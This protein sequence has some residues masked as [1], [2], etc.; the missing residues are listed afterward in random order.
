MLSSLCLPSLDVNQGFG[1]N[2]YIDFQIP[3]LWLSSF[4]NFPLDFVSL[5]LS[6]SPSDQKILSE[7][8]LPTMAP[9]G[10][11]IF[12]NPLVFPQFQRILSYVEGLVF[13]L[14]HHVE[15][16]ILDSLRSSYPG[17]QEMWH[18]YPLSRSFVF[19]LVLQMIIHENNCVVCGERYFH[20][21]F[22]IITRL[23]IS[24][25]PIALAVISNNKYIPALFLTV[26]GKDLMFY[27]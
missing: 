22:P 7:C 21:S 27:H 25:P 12:L 9:N 3:D 16:F 8:Y 11:N 1:Q 18:I 15:L 23:I 2:L 24:F 19:F 10:A 14:T 20:V 4:Q 5:T 13:F 17:F 6:S 26:G